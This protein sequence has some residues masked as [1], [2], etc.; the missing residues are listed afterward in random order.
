LTTDVTK[1]GA[2]REIVSAPGPFLFRNEGTVPAAGIGWCSKQGL[3]PTINDV[4]TFPMGIYP[5][6]DLGQTSAFFTV[7]A[8]KRD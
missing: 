2:Q 3:V 4:S 6:L 1:E 5:P 7:L 8:L